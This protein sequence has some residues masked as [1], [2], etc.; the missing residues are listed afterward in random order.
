MSIIISYLNSSHRFPEWTCNH[1]MSSARAIVLT[2]SA[3][4]V[5]FLKPM[6][7]VFLKRPEVHY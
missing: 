2:F 6:A 5:A 1:S 3:M 7:I 4:A